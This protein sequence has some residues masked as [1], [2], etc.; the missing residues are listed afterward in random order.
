[1]SILIQVEKVKSEI[2]SLFFLF[3]SVKITLAYLVLLYFL[4]KEVM[5][6]DPKKNYYEI[7]GVAEDATPDEIKKTFRKAAVQHHPDRWGSKEKF[8]EVNEAYQVLSD[9]K[10]RQQYDMYRKGW[11]GAG[12]FDFG[13]FW[14]GGA[15]FDFWGFGDIG[16]LLGGMFGGGFWG[17]T[18]TRRQTK[19]EDL[20]KQIEISFEESYLGV[21]K[22][23][24][25][26]R[27][28]RAEGI[29]EEACSQCQG[30]GRVTQQAQ[31]PF[32][33]FQTQAA[34]PH[35]SGFWKI[36]KK[37]GKQVQNGGLEPHKETLDLEIPAGIKSGSYLKY[38]EKGSEAMGGVPTGDLYIK[39]IVAESEKY[40]RKTDDLRVK[41]EVSL[42][43]VVLGGE[44]EVSHPEGKIKVKIPKGTQIWQ[45][46]RVA[47]KGF[48]ESGLFKHKGDMIVELQIPIPKKLSKEQ[49]KLWKELQKTN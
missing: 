30:T 27:H 43:D 33:V 42:F 2:L 25:Y 3:K 20:E 41:A 21:K 45:K 6:F 29:I 31:T 17:T 23:I 16:D 32:G 49:E 5:D 36:Y 26:T 44:V 12:G 46:V 37:D 38:A 35:C 19:G 11:F 40:Q 4:G 15:Q 14:G 48:W 9:E 28:I 24:A 22:K 47:G 1:M 7:L 34:C 18:R 13:G 39:I 8:Q 10:K